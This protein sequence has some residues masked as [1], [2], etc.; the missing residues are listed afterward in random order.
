[1]NKVLENISPKYLNLILYI[2]ERANDVNLGKKKLFKLL[3]FV[4]FDYYERHQKSIT[5][6]NYIVL[7]YG[8]VP[9]KGQ[10]VLN[11]MEGQNLI[12][13]IKAKRA[14]YD[15]IR[16]MPHQKADL[17]VFDGEEFEHINSVITRF[18][19]YDGATIERAAKNDIPF[20][21]TN[22][23]GEKKIDY[24]LVFYRASASEDNEN[25]ADK[26]ILNSK[27]FQNYLEQLSR[28]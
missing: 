4:D 8:P 9:E 26:I 3:Y 2:L 11:A 17:S 18:G 12:E 1:M 7:Q 28:T 23:S 19:D 21:A 14:I 25:E 22:E 20:R 24:D 27:P 6:E 15:Q 5:G 16:F 10:A 13:S